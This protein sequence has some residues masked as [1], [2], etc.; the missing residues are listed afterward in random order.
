MMILSD[1]SGRDAMMSD[2]DVRSCSD[3]QKK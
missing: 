2:W 1:T 3:G